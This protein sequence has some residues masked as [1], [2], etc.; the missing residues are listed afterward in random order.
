MAAVFTGGPTYA[1]TGDMASAG[2]F[3]LETSVGGV[4]G[5]IDF[6]ES[7][8]VDGVGTKNYGARPNKIRLRVCYVG[9]SVSDVRGAWATDYLALAAQPR[10]LVLDGGSYTFVF[11]GRASSRETIK[12]TGFG[13]FFAFAT[14][15]GQGVR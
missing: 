13:T 4:H 10:A 5:E 7:P 2:K 15:A 6:I 1:D 11:D 8:G 3:M 9:A 12:S 14:V